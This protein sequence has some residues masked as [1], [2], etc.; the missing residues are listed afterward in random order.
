MQRRLVITRYGLG[1]ESDVRDREV[2]LQQICY[3]APH[4]FR[5]LPATNRN[6]LCQAGNVTR[7]RPQMQVMNAVHA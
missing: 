1:L 4:R 5:I 6:V 7:H 2:R 3:G